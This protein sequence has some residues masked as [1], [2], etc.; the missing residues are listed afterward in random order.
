M[1]RRDRRGRR[2]KIKDLMGFSLDCTVDC[3]IDCKKKECSTHRSLELRGH[4]CQHYS[5]SYVIQLE[6]YILRTAILFY[7][8]WNLGWNVMTNV[9]WL[10]NRCLARGRINPILLKSS[11]HRWH[12]G[13]LRTRL[14]SFISFLFW[15]KKY[16]LKQNTTDAKPSF[17]SFPA[18]PS[19]INARWCDT[20]WSKQ[21]F[22]QQLNIAT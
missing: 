19:W 14:L 20:V 10:C 7:F 13:T 5:W 15:A 18:S 16:F 17:F 9:K 12:R 1:K 4:N 2:W 3:A 21:R 11:F 6:I 8:G 22:H